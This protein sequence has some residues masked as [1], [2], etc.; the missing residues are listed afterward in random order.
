MLTAVLVLVA[1]IA[2]FA[3]GEVVRSQCRRMLVRPLAL[4]LNA[5]EAVGSEA[6]A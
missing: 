5:R 1:V 6:H 3:A 2:V 4:Q